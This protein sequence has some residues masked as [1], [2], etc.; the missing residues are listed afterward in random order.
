MSVVNAPDGDGESGVS[1]HRTVDVTR[2]DDGRYLAS[3]HQERWSSCEDFATREDAIAYGNEVLAPESLQNGQRFYTGRVARI[4]S[5]ELAEAAV[6][7]EMVIEQMEEHLNQEIGRD[8]DTELSVSLR[9]VDDLDARLQVTIKQWLDDHSIEPRCYRI[10]AIEEH[11]FYR[12]VAQR[13]LDDGAI[14]R[15]GRH[16][17]H[18]G[19]HQWD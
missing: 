8:V 15:C 6:S 11:T 18:E 3:T 14:I 2:I 19:D 4:E 7:V 5:L 9:A 16:Q 10:V 17:H 1:Q 13:P 12:C